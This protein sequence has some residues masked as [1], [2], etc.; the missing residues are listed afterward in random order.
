VVLPLRDKTLPSVFAALDT[1]FR[2]VGGVSTYTLTDNEKTV[3]VEHVAGIPV[4]NTQMVAW[5]WHYETAVH[6]C[7]PADPASKGGTEASVKISKADL[8]PTEANLR[9]D[10]ACFAELEAACGEFCEKVNGRPH[11]VTRRAPV[12][13]LAEERHHL[14]PVPVHP[15]TVAFGVTRAVPPNTSMVSFEAGQYSVPHTLV[16][17]TVWVRPHGLGGDEQVVIVHVGGS[18]PVEVA[19]HHRATPGSPRTIDE[20]FPPQPAGAVDRAPKARTAS[21]AEFLALGEGA[22]LWLVEAAAAGTTKMRVKMTEAL[23]LAKLF[24]AT[25]VDWRWA[26]CG[27]TGFAEADLA[28]ILDHHARR[29]AAG[30]HRAGEDRSLTQGTAAWAELGR[31]DHRQSHEDARDAHEPRGL[32]DRDGV[33][34]EEEVR[35]CST[36]TQQSVPTVGVPTAPP[37]PTDLEQLLRRLRLPHVRRHA[38][39]V[40]ATAKAQRWDPRQG[41]QDP[42][43][44]GGRRPGQ[45]RAGHQEDG[46]RVP[47]RQ[48]LRRLGSRPVL[49]PGTPPQQALRT[50]E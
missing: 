42:A 50:L 29:P 8:V 24:G 35:A 21:E 38:P 41:P 1:T 43:G 11:R 9:G 46:R 4:R 48:D 49:H 34:G 17:E 39:E 16:G 37:L 33:G 10:Y 30:E 12:E 36:T 47:H 44:G 7:E 40:L 26:R 13:M 27:C 20:H 5:A 25:E 18:G 3:T 19:R 31:P 45:V 15:H 2:R 32:T 23:A 14:H 22:R 6:T 28:S